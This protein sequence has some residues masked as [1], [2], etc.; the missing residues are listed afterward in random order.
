MNHVARRSWLVQI[1]TAVSTVLLAVGLSMG[2]VTPAHASVPTGSI[3]GTV[4]DSNGQAIAGAM[5]FLRTTDGYAGATVKQ[6]V[7]ATNGAFAL[8]A[9]ELGTYRLVI[10]GRSTGHEALRWTSAG[11]EVFSLTAA[12]LVADANLALGATVTGSVLVDGAATGGVRVCVGGDFDDN[13]TW[14]N[15]AGSYTLK[16]VI[17]WGASHQV[18]VTAYPRDG[19]SWVETTVPSYGSS[20]PPDYFE[21]EPGKTYSQDIPITSVVQVSGTVTDWQGAPVAGAS[22]CV[23]SSCLATTDGAGKYQVRQA[24]GEYTA[25]ASYAGLTSD[26]V[27]GRLTVG[28][29]RIVDFQLP[30]GALVSGTVTDWQGKP[31]PS[32]SICVSTTS[33]VATTDSTGAYSVRQ[34]EGVYRAWA[35]SG[36]LSSAPV[37]GTLTNGQDLSGI[38]FKLA[39]GKLKVATPKV[40]GSVKVGK[41]LTAKAGTW[42]PSPVKLVFKWYANGKAIK[43]ATKSSYKIA[44]S[45][46]GKKI[47]VKVT[48]SKAGYATVTKASKATKKVAK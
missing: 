2:G 7:S 28:Q 3:S 34:P 6:A 39:V 21:V 41:K 42:G 30:A 26:H 43:G 27:T 23:V 16:G 22:V 15:S 4:R 48:G 44:K 25:W 19:Q 37:N 13:C 8:T 36:A 18:N 24:V 12:G 40:S 31:V 9:V 1:R 10:D 5:V 14:S 11:N 46:K 17:G 38:N 29:S 47:T 33:C 32:A 45:V 20:H 35:V